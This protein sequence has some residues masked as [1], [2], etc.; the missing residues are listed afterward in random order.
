MNP[1]AAQYAR[2]ESQADRLGKEGELL[3]ARVS[4]VRVNSSAGP[5][6]VQISESG[7]APMSPIKPRK[8]LVLAAAAL[9]GWLA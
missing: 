3:D 7:Q 9:V 8:A 4:E 6:N 2:L 1:L 5:L